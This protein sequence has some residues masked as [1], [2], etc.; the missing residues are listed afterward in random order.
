MAKI[1]LRAGKVAIKIILPLV[2]I[3]LIFYSVKALVPA[4]AEVASGPE[5]LAAQF[6][7]A[8]AY[9]EKGQYEDAEQVY[10]GILDNHPGTD[11]ALY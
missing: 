1:I 11:D 6:D 2:I 3:G 4:Q 5:E 10:L 7:E 8:E 9:Q